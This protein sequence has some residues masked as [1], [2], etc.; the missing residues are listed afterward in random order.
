MTGN[1]DRATDTESFRKPHRGFFFLALF[2]AEF[3]DINIRQIKE[4]AEVS[5][6]RIK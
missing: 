3:T 5:A 6:G 2:R 4:R 1:D